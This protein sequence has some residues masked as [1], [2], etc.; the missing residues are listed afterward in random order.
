ME[1]ENS[2]VVVLDEGRNDV[3]ELNT[4]CSGTSARQ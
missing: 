4:C 1:T 3:E 2:A